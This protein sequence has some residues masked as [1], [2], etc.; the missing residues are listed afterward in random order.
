MRWCTDW[1]ALN[2]VTLKVIELKFGGRYP[3]SKNP[4]NFNP[5]NLNDHAQDRHPIGDCDT[6]LAR[7]GRSRIFS[8]C[9]AMGAFHCVAMA[10]EDREKT[11][12]STPWGTYQF[13]MMGFGLCK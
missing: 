13:R 2:R 3:K 7:L 11:S 6:N 10:K 5:N 1:R 4:K 8:T 9:D 12:F